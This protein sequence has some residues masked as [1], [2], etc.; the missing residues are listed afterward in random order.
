MSFPDLTDIAATTIESRSKIVA[1]NVTKNNALYARL[2]EKG[3]VKYF[4][5]GSKI[6]QELSFAENANSGWYSGFDLLPVAAQDVIS[7]AEF[8]IKQLACPVVISGLEMLQNNDKEKMIDLLEAR[9]EVAENTMVNN[10]AK[11]CYADGTG[12]GGKELTGLRAGVVIGS[13]SVGTGTAPATGT[14]GGIDRASWSFWRNQ[15]YYGG[16]AGSTVAA[17][18]G[19]WNTLYASLVRGKDHPDLIV[20]GNTHWGNY[21][22]SLQAIQRFTDSKL[23]DLGFSTAKFMTSDVVLDGGIGGYVG[24]EATIGGAATTT[25]MAYFLNTD[26]LFLRPHKDRDMVP[27]SPNKR[28]SIN[29]DAE[30]EVIGWAGNMTCSGAQ[31]Q[32]YYLGYGT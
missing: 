9:I 30:V 3:H 1:D 22:G 20:T 14:Y 2:S 25:P 31:F 26:F 16:T 4:S 13:G 5:G 8:S 15:Y 11:G 21:M 10:L 19:S 32:G 27:L 7:A 29:Q 28:Y 12:S 18:Q 23:A 24:G 6:L 17:I